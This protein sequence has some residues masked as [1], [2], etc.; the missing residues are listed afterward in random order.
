MKQKM[1]SR[2][3]GLVLGQQLLGIEDLHYGLWDGDLE[4]SLTNLPVAQQ[5]Y[6]DFLVAALPPAQETTRILDV[7]C[8][9]GHI[10]GQCLRRGYHVDGVSPSPS[11]SKLV[12][13][14]LEHFPDND[15]TLFECRFEDFP[16][17][18]QKKTYDVVLFS[19]SF[20][21]I[22]METAFTIIAPVLKPG[23]KV[24]ICDFFQ[25]AATGD[26]APGDGSFGG[27]HPL[28][29]FYELLERIPF[30]L[31]RDED[32]TGRVSP[33]IAL[34]NDLLMNKIGPAAVSIGRYFENRRPWLYRL[35]VRLFRKRL[36]KIQFKYLSGHRSAE[37]FER[38]KSYRL[39]VL[40][41]RAAS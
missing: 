24:V 20:Q 7:G 22:P 12:R 28:A 17:E 5:R 11:L 30:D 2:E 31:E 10:L 23:G 21:Y 33:N 36:D 40:R 35:F 6:T 15:S 9:T 38:Y 26:G 19:E 8:G 25:T 41:L 18:E 3:L 14:Q 37:T 27:G 32:I 1:D 34:L 4:L 29:A 16:W 39:L 13:Q